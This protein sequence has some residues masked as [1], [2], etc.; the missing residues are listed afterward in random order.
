[1]HFMT[2]LWPRIRPLLACVARTQL[3]ALVARVGRSLGDGKASPVLA[4]PP[5]PN[6][7]TTSGTA[8]TGLRDPNATNGLRDPNAVNGL[9]DPNAMSAASPP[10]QAPILRDG[11]PGGTSPP[12]SDGRAARRRACVG[13]RER[14]EV[15][16]HRHAP[17]GPPA[18]RGGEHQTRE[19]HGR[20][21]L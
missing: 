9:R 20:D 21:L 12:A 18:A 14:P 1:M 11:A 5:S 2:S 7:S 8:M 17:G 19:R 16:S 13:R 10:L 4:R 6:A 3:L 15:R